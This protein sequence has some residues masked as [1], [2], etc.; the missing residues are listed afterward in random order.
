MT[1]KPHRNRNAL[2]L[3]GNQAVNKPDV[4]QVIQHVMG[5]KIGYNEL[6]AGFTL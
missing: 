4:P 3:V 5:N 6:L 2:Y 1:G